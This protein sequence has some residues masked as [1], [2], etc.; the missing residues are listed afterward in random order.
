MQ[1]K[2]IVEVFMNNEENENRKRNQ[3]V[4]EKTECDRQRERDT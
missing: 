4:N 3:R 1:T 2:E